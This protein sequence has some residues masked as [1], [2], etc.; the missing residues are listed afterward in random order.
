MLLHYLVKLQCMKKSYKF[1]DTL[2]KDIVLKYFVWM[3][4]LNF[5]FLVKIECQ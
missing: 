2:L 1:E 4:L 3:Y 5:F